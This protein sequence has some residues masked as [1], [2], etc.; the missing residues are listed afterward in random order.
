M[1]WCSTGA[2][3][4]PDRPRDRGRGVMDTMQDPQRPARGALRRREFLRLSGLAGLGVA[5][6]LSGRDVALAKPTGT[7]TIAQGADLTSLDPQQ[8]QGTAG[9][10]VM[11]S[12]LES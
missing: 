10:S 8:T 11:R 12:F 3:W 9:R 1:R 2:G 4:S 7:L 5:S 6:A